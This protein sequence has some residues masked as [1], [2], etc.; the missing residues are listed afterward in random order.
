MSKLIESISNA[1]EEELPK[2]SQDVLIENSTQAYTENRPITS[3]EY[4]FSV[5]CVDSDVA[6]W[7]F[8]V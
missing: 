3:Q 7:A 6:D 4:G 5:G 1:Q 8:D 2:R